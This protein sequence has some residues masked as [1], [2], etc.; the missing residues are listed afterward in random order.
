VLVISMIM[1]RGP[2]ILKYSPKL[3]KFA[4]SVKWQSSD[5]KECPH[6]AYYTS[7][8]LFFCK[9]DSCGKIQVI[10]VSKWNYF[11]IFRIPEKFDV[12]TTYL[13]KEFKNLQK[14]LHPDKFSTK[15]EMEKEIS[16]E[17]SSVVNKA[18]RVL[19]SP[20]H[21]ASYMVRYITFILRALCQSIVYSLSYEVLMHWARAQK[22]MIPH[23][24]YVRRT[25]WLFRK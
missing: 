7:N 18:Y 21:R 3:F 11:Q 4:N 17:N 5:A 15:S 1:L 2:S 13:E 12:D 14:Q 25:N 8:S 19:R 22:S 6:C 23:F 24:L 9:S 20:L 10:D 16:T